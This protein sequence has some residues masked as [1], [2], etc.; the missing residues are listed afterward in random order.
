MADVGIVGAGI[1][2]L[3]TAHA[4]TRRGASVV[5]YDRAGPGSGQ[6]AGEARIFRHAHADARLVA[7]A[8]DSR[9]LWSEWGERFGVELISGDGAV[10]IGSS[11]DERLRV[12]R[13]AGGVPARHIGADELAE[14]LPILTGYAGP[15]MLDEH[16]GSIRTRAAIEALAGE[17]GDRLVRDEVLLVRPTRSGT[18]EVRTGLRRAEHDRVVICAGRDSPRLAR[19]LGLTLPVRLAA[20]VRLRFAVRGDPP[21][22]LACLQ[23]GSGDFGEVGVYATATPGNGAYAVGLSQTTAMRE[24]ASPVETDGLASLSARAQAYVTRALPGLHP[25]PSAVVHCWVTDLPWSE[26]GVAIWEA[27]DVQVIAGHNLFKQAPG[28]GRALAAAALGEHVPAELRPEARLGA[29]A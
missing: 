4:L 22:R 11:V 12:L 7:F 24:D 19:A 17:L 18:V 29:G 28:L 16:G 26:D 2:G 15:A 25:E 23:D 5:V 21:A 1:V 13:E 14:R 27:G 20:H 8:R 3:A 9:A 6:S 10:A